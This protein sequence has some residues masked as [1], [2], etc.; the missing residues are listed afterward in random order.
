MHKERQ[1]QPPAAVITRK[2][3]SKIKI[4]A[5]GITLCPSLDADKRALKRTG[6]KA[7]E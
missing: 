4:R 1:P 3:I 2:D 5:E 6:F 7:M